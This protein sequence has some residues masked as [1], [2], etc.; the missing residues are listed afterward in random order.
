MQQTFKS[1][2]PEFPDS[3]R[4]WLY[5]S[6]RKLVDREIHFLEKKL[7]LF[8]KN[9][10]AHGKNLK[11]NATILLS[12]YLIFVVDQNDESAS[13]CSIDSSVH[14]IKELGMEL[15]LDFFTR[16]EVLVL[17]GNQTSLLSYFKAVEQKKIFINPMIT[18]LS[19]LRKL[20]S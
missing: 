7:E 1:L 4:I 19:E 12:Y 16:S 3:S 17:D 5:L 14:F 20:K 8:L 2:F 9:W 13:G 15:G 11:C 6:N 18:E 10:S